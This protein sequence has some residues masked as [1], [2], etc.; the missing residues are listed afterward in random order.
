MAKCVKTNELFDCQI[1]YL[2]ELFDNAE[3]PWEILPKIKA[4]AEKLITEGI[5]GYTLYA[6]NVLIEEQLAQKMRLRKQ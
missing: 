2:K 5:E 4:H 3:Y 1:P 6:P